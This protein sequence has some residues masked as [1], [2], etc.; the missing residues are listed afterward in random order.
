MKNKERPI[1]IHNPID[2]PFLA[3]DLPFF[4]RIGTPIFCIVK[5]LDN[6]CCPGCYGIIDLII[7]N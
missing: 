4:I 6:L 7:L 1:K 2:V 3:Y 5:D